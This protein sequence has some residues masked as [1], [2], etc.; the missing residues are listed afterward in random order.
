MK[1]LIIGF[2]LIHSWYSQEC[3]TDK[4]CRPVNCNDIKAVEFGFMYKN[5]F[6][7]KELVHPSQ[8]GQCHACYV[9]NGYQPLG[10]CLYLPGTS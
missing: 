1:L 6:F 7:R 10:Y 2:I 4:D 9:T 3:C 8:D 5:L